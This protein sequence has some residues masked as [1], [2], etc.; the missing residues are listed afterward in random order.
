MKNPI[1]LL[2]L[3]VCAVFYGQE[4]D[5]PK[6]NFFERE[7]NRYIEL[8]G[9]TDR[10][11]IIA[12]TQVWPYGEK[13]RN[14]LVI[15]PDGKVYKYAFINGKDLSKTDNKPEIRNTEI[16]G[17]ER[18]HFIELLKKINTMR[19]FKANDLEAFKYWQT[20]EKKPNTTV[21]LDGRSYS[22]SIYKN[23]DKAT[24]FTSNPESYIAAKRDGYKLKEEF[25]AIFKEFDF[26]E[27]LFENTKN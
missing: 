4:H 7:N 14:F 27:R 9:I 10:N 22:I 24:Y 20:I 2:L 11:A 15:L 23:R 6:M 3:P 26:G 18:L 5:I 1:L 19:I 13:F 12:T 25:L 16:V 17:E 21:V 8:L